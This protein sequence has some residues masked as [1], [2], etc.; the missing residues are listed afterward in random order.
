MN[1]SGLNLN[2]AQNNN[3]KLTIMKITTSLDLSNP[4]GIARPAVRGFFPSITRSIIRLKPKAAL[5]APTIASRI[6]PICGQEGRLP[7]TITDP[8]TAPMN[9]NGSANNVCSILIISKK[10]A[11]FLNMLTL[12]DSNVQCRNASGERMSLNILQS[13][14]TEDASQLIPSWKKRQRIREPFILLITF[15][16]QF[17]E[18][19]QDVLKICLVNSLERLPSRF[20]QFQTYDL[21]ARFDD[22]LHL[23]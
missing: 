6:Q 10:I 20:G 12:L 14:F 2:D 21:P 8:N 16:E 23:L 17:A 15:G 19:G 5:R 1:A 3:T 11:I 18:H 9:A 22:S 7:V 13:D 4:A